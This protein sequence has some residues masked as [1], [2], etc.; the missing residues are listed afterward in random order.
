MK[1]TLVC[2]GAFAT[3]VLLLVGTVHAAPNL[4]GEWKLNLA[5]S[6]Y[7]KFPTPLAMTRTITHDG[8]TLAMHSV[9]KSAQGEVASDLRYT[10]DG[11]ESINKVQGGEAKGAAQWI[12]DKLMLESA[13]EFHRKRIR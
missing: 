2:L 7:G 11:K 9:Q 13:R 6:N 5:K 4:T 8:L 3:A 1:R 12:G 10:T